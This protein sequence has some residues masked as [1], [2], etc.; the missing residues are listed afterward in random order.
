MLLVRSEMLHGGVSTTRSLCSLSVVQKRRRRGRE[1]KETAA[2]ERK[3]GE[4]RVRFGVRAKV[5]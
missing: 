3:E 5:S 2:A 1:Q 4:A